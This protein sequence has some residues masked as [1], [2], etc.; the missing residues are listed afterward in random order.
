MN[1]V[2]LTSGDV[3]VETPEGR[4]TIP[5]SGN[6]AGLVP[7]ED[8]MAVLDVSTDNGETVHIPVALV[9]GGLGLGEPAALPDEQ[10]GTLYIVPASVLLT[11]G[12]ARSD[13]IA[14]DTGPTAIRNDKGRIVAIT[15]FITLS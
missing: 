11:V 5:V 15:R 12:A 7:L 2:N 8:G 4:I 13:L 14:P 1:I 10:P 6:Y 3:T 9:R